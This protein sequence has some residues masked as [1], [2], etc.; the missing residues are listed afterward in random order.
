MENLESIYDTCIELFKEIPSAIEFVPRAY[1][2]EELCMAAIKYSVRCD[3]DEMHIWDKIPS[4]MITEK[5]CEAAAIYNQYTLDKIPAK[6][7]SMAVY[8]NAVKRKGDLLEKIPLAA[9]NED[10]YYEAVRQNGMNIKFVPEEKITEKLCLK[11]YEQTAQAAE[12][13]PKQFLTAD[14]CVAALNYSSIN[15]RY[16]WFMEHIVPESMKDTVAAQYSDCLKH[17]AAEEKNHTENIMRVRNEPLYIKQ[18][19]EEKRDY[20]ICESAVKADGMLLRFVPERIRTLRLCVDAVCNDADALLYVPEDLRN[21]V[22]KSVKFSCQLIGILFGNSKYKK[23]FF[24]RRLEKM[25][26]Q[27]LIESIMKRLPDK[28]VKEVE[29]IKEKTEEYGADWATRQFQ[30]IVRKYLS[31]D[32]ELMA[33]LDEDAEA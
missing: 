26:E 10:M 6:Y 14:M 2:T 8:T 25:N 23:Y 9:Q 29:E 5:V 7:K 12:Y 3:Y 15:K 4:E 30:L 19:P 16:D 31:D 22:I 33:L 18:I 27:E 17:K 13:I 24:I 1:M 11:A 28:A 32:K 21:D 20:D